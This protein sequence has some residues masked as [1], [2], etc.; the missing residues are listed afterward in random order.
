LR[1]VLAGQ[2]RPLHK[3][4]RWLPVRLNGASGL[5]TTAACTGGPTAALKVTWCATD[6]AKLTAHGRK[7]LQDF[8]SSAGAFGYAIYGHTDSRASDEYNIDLSQRRA[9]AVGDV[10][11]SVGASVERQLGFGERQ[12]IASNGS[13]AGMAKNRRVEIV[14]YRW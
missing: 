12:P 11:R 14:C 4:D 10:A 13:S 2:L 3:K 5:M 1:L 6:S 9:K 7:R 8:F